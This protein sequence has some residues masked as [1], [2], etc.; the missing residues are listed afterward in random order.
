M[1]AFLLALTLHLLGPAQEVA[2]RAA[3]ADQAL[4]VMLAAAPGSGRNQPVG[5]I[6]SQ[7]WA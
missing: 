5:L 1:S 7:S 6:P 2:T 4:Q 3:L